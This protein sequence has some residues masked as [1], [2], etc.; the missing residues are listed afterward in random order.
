MVV[1]AMFGGGLGEY[2]T[3]EEH[4]YY[5]TMAECERNMKWKEDELMS[6]PEFRGASITC[7]SR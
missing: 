4:I 1:I 5:G 3:R 2:D 7:K 6:D